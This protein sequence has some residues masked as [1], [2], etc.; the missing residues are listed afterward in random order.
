LFG[1]GLVVNGFDL[2]DAI[3][4]PETTVNCTEA[5]RFIIEDGYDPISFCYSRSFTFAEKCCLTCQ[6]IM[7]DCI[8]QVVDCSRFASNCESRL[9]INGVAIGRACRFTCS[10]C[11]S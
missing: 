9:T 10:N 7:S 8:D 11:K 5:I 2:G 3:F 1:D 6:K 4:L